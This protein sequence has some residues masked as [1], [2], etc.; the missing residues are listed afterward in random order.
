MGPFKMATPCRKVV[1]LQINISE[2]IQP[3]IGRFIHDKARRNKNEKG[4]GFERKDE[5]RVYQIQGLRPPEREGRIQRKQKKMPPPRSRT[6]PTDQD[7]TDVW[8]TAQTFKWSAVPF[9]VRQGYISNTSENQG[10]IPSSYGNL[11]LMKPPNFLH[12]TPA[13]IKKH[14]NAIKKFCTAWPKGLETEELCRKHFPL[15]A[16]TS[17]YVF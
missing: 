12:L 14:C 3:I 9:P 8:P 7:W 10:I 2:K 13:H 17:D 4:D 11:E 16:V 15:E 6:M 5:F 1:A